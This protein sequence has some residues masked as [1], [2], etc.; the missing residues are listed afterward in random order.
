MSITL[1]INKKFD[2]TLYVIEEM[3]NLAVTETSGYSHKPG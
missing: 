2:A 1:T 3:Y